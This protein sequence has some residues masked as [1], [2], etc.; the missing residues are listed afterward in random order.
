[1]VQMENNMFFDDLKENKSDI[2]KDSLFRNKK[3]VQSNQSKTEDTTENESVNKKA[4][5]CSPEKTRLNDF[6]NRKL[7]DF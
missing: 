2:S 7:S 4:N 3:I 1:M 6:F 5:I